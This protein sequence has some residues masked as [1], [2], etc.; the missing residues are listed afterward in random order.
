MNTGDS[1]R[2]T[3][4]LA[5]Y[6]SSNDIGLREKPDPVSHRYR[7]CAK[8]QNPMKNAQ[9]IIAGAGPVGSFAGYFL[10]SRGIDVVVLEAEASCTKDM[11]ASTF[12]PPTLEMLDDLGLAEGM[13]AQGLVAPEYQ[14]RDRQTGEVFSF[15]LSELSD[16]TRFPYR[17]QC[18]QFKMAMMVSDLL[19]NH[20]HADLRFNNKIVHF[21]EDDDGVNVNVETPYTIETLKADFLIG[22][23]G[24]DSIVRKWLNVQFTGF[25]YP[26][27]FL[28]LSTNTPLEDS[29]DNLCYVNYLADPKEWLVLLRSPTAWRVLIP[30][31]ESDC[32]DVLLSD[33]YKTDVFNRLTGDGAAVSTNHRT[34]YRVHQRVAEKYN[35]GRVAIIGDAAHLNNPLGGLG[36]NSGIHDAWS[37]CGKLEKILKNG[38]AMTPL[39]DEFDAERRSVMNRFIQAQTIKNKNMMEADAPQTQRLY[40]EELA[41]I[42]ADDR[43]RRDFLLAQSMLKVPEAVKDIELAS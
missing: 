33:D 19:A 42:L 37:L 28:T 10:A 11:R 40:K 6:F 35:C 23:D 25:T 34:V 38:A 2:D 32:D 24:A 4:R 41:R 16:V 7:V 8:V 22:A 12:H 1:L 5:E 31:R 43:E 14:Y 18:E 9:V 20:P 36:M 29:F 39:L 15:D 27:K 21:Q 3:N 30:A 13:I 17:L 26:E